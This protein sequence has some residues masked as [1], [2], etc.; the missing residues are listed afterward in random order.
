MT[1]PAITLAAE[2]HA[3]HG[4]YTQSNRSPSG[5]LV[6]KLGEMEVYASEHG[7]GETRDQA[8]RHLTA[9][10]T[11]LASVSVGSDEDRP[12]RHRAAIAITLSAILAFE[13]ALRT[14]VGGR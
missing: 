1:S 8:I 4:A 5:D 10:T 13:T 11:A 3:L 12:D 7:H 9:A 2:A 6:A 14:A